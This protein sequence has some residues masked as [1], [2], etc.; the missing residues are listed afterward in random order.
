MILSLAHDSGVLS[1]HVPKAHALLGAQ[2]S[3]SQCDSQYRAKSTRWVAGGRQSLW[4]TCTWREGLGLC[5]LCVAIHVE[6]AEVRSVHTARA[7]GS[8]SLSVERDVNP[9]RDNAARN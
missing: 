7:G 5:V 1:T 9:G 6:D 8:R 4:N 2:L 3:D